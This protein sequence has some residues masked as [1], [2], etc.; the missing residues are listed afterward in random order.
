MQHTSTKYA[1]IS[2]QLALAYLV[3]YTIKYIIHFVLHFQTIL[4][5]NM[6][7]IL[8]N[9]LVTIIYLIIQF[10]LMYTIYYTQ[11]LSGFAL[12]KVATTIITIGALYLVF[13]NGI[14][15]TVL[16]VLILIF[17]LNIQLKHTK[18]YKKDALD[19]D[20]SQFRVIKNRRKK[21][22]KKPNIKKVVDDDEFVETK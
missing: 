3:F 15:A 14:V 20:S 1:Q 21:R 9:L 12:E 2:L 19:F 17:G 4:G 10:F 6:Q 16:A 8:L 7:A 5:N 13:I 11:Q 22:R 18:Y